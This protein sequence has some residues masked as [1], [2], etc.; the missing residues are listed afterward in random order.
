MSSNNQLRPHLQQQANALKSKYPMISPQ[1][2]TEILHWYDDEIGVQIGAFNIAP[3][4]FTTVPFE[5]EAF[6]AMGKAATLQLVPPANDQDFEVYSRV[7]LQEDEETT[8][9]MAVLILRAIPSLS[10]DKVK[11]IDAAI[12]PEDY[13]TVL[14]AANTA[15]RTMQGAVIAI[16]TNLFKQAESKCSIY[17]GT[18]DSKTIVLPTG[19]TA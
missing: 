18:P 5:K 10:Y 7:M 11:G 1:R 19:A 17:Q 8:N 13:I 4:D 16:Q 9:D 12:T 3:F 2:L 6:K 15:F 14:R